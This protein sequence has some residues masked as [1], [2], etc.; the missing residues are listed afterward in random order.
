MIKRVVIL[1]HTGFIGSKIEHSL[2]KNYPALEIVGISRQVLDLTKDANILG[3]Y[4]DHYT[5]IIMCAMVKK[6]FGDNLDNF[7]KNIA[8]ITNVGNVLGQ[9]PVARFVYF[10]SAAVYGENVHNLSITEETHIQPTSFYGL[11]KFASEKVL[12]KVLPQNL[13]IIRPPVIYGPK[14]MPAYGPSGFLHAARSHEPITLWGEGTEKR[15]FIFVDDVVALIQQLLFSDYTGTLNVVSGK[16]YTFVEIIETI[17][18]ITQLPLTITS[19]ERT[20]PKVDHHFNNQKLKALFPAF[21]FTPLQ[22]GIEKMYTGEEKE[23]KNEQQ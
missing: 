15:E 1:G 18:S 6:Q 10:S 20:Q 12:E 4:F 19:R 5:A 16:S 17:K 3:S 9:H 2:R 7:K 21:V 23:S 8:M 13:V 22:K 11:A 14:D